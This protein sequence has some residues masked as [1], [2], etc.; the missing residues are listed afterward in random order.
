MTSKEMDFRGQ[1]LNLMSFSGFQAF[2]WQ[3]QI[4]SPKQEV[5]EKPEK[6]VRFKDITTETNKLINKTKTFL[7]HANNNNAQ[8]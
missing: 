5:R 6:P 4:F 7:N 2:V 3:N 1:S 8:K